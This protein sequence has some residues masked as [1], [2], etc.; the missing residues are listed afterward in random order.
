MIGLQIAI[1][2]ICLLYIAASVY[3]GC[4]CCIELKKWSFSKVI[5]SMVLF[6]LGLVN[7]IILFNIW[8]I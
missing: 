8:T 5:F 7:M 6:I 2:F 4:K 3:I 1:S